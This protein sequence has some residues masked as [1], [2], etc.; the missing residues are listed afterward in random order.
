ML[1]LSS[2]TDGAGFVGPHPRRASVHDGGQIEGRPAR[3]LAADRSRDDADETEKHDQRPQDVRS[4]RPTGL[5]RG[6]CVAHRSPPCRCSPWAVWALVV[7]LD[8][9]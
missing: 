4:A 8:F 2:P 7:V 3:S 6:T 1:L 5:G 9:V